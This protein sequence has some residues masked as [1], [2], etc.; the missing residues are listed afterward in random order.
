[1]ISKG[2]YRELLNNLGFE[3]V[4]SAVHSFSER[5]LSRFIPAEIIAYESPGKNLWLICTINDYE[6][7]FD[8]AYSLIKFINKNEVGI[9]WVK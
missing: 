3:L 2:T 4:S 6:V 8:D 9:K 1:M 7:P 5:Y